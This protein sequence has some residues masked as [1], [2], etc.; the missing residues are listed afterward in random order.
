M[1]GRLPSNASDLVDGCQLSLERSQGSVLG[2]KHCFPSVFSFPFSVGCWKCF[3]GPCGSGW[4]M[5][6]RMT[7]L[8]SHKRRLLAVSRRTIIHHPQVTVQTVA[9][10]SHGRRTCAP[11][12]GVHAPSVSWGE[13]HMA[14]YRAELLLTSLYLNQGI[15][16]FFH[17]I[18]RTS[19]DVR[20]ENGDKLPAHRWHL[21]PRSGEFT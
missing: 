1:G 12:A 2:H 7:A 20:E 18:C 13:K 8:N 4:K 15:H 3:Y 16:L 10:D 6:W 21:G 17:A 14:R 19:L 9:A 5:I 11:E